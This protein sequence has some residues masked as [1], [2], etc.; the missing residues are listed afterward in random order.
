MTVKL[1]R[2]ALDDERIK[3]CHQIVDDLVLL[4][5]ETDPAHGNLSEPGKKEKALQALNKIGL[6]TGILTEWAENQ[7]F[8]VYYQVAKSEDQWIDGKA[9]DKHDNEMMWYGNNLPEDVF[10]NEDHLIC[11]RAAIA[12]ILHN[13]F[14][15]YGRMGWRM[16][17]K[18][19]LYALNEGQVDWLLTPTNTNQQGNAY[20]LQTLKWAAVKH[21]YKLIGEGWKKTA[22]QQKVAESCGATFQAIKKW[23]KQAIKERDQDGSTLKSLQI[24][25]T[26][27]SASM[28]FSEEHTEE[29]IMQEAL[30]WNLNADSTNDKEAPLKNLSFGIIDALKLVEEYPLKTLKDRLIN[31]GMRS[32]S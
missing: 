5:R 14:S 11:E 13:T 15:K 24:G 12:D 32:I 20:E 28:K 10:S 7:I 17:L 25:A 9:C 8:G 23:E 2:P 21:I 4:S 29:T 22:A 18:E 27:V 19:S 16:A 1:S 26:F 6:L 3:Q 31:A 30:H